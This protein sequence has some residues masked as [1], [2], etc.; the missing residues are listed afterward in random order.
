MLKLLF[1]LILLYIGYRIFKMFR[2][3]KSQK[4]K[5]YRVDTPPPEEDLVQD[6]FCKIYVPRSSAYAQDINGRPQYFCSRE[7][8]EKY[9]SEKTTNTQ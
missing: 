5:G 2:D 9:L 6:P 8:C 1:I 3:G 4:V 7:C